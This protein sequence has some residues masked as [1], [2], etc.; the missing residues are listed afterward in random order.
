MGNERMPVLFIGHGSPMNAINNNDYTSDLKKLAGRIP[1]PD[2]VLVIS[3]HWLTNGT[4]IT[5][6]GNPEQIYDFY[7]FPEELYKI[8]YQPSGSPETAAMVYSSVRGV[9]ITPDEDRGIDHAA[10]AVL[11]HIYPGADIPVLELSIDMNLHPEQH[12][13]TGKA[14][15]FLRDK[16]LLIV[17]SGNIV[18]N[19]AMMDY[20]EGVTPREWAV[21]FD[22]KVKKCLV[23]NDHEGLVQYEK[24]GKISRYSVPTDEHFLP[25]LYAAALRQDG[26]RLD[27]IHEAIHHGT[28]SMRCFIIG[29]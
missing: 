1:L 6:G 12:Y 28:I 21:E 9:S 23:E 10:W 14:L 4:R 18:H 19:L 24:W 5:S 27:F 7:G 15:S 3:A 22:E 25:V 29:G 20:Y 8:K 2:A 16:G 17:S 13:E 26:E 11:K